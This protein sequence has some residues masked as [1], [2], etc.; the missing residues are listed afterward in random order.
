LAAGAGRAEYLAYR[1]ACERHG[2]PL[3]PIAVLRNVWVGDWPE[4]RA[5]ATYMQTSYREWYGEA[6]DLPVDTTEPQ[7]ANGY[8]LPLDWYWIGDSGFIAE[9]VEASHEEVPFDQLIMVMHFPGMDAEQSHASITR[10]ATDVLARF[11]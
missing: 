9:Q 2:R 8:P 4:A 6:G 10:F 7:P 1:A 5:Y 11:K 3:G